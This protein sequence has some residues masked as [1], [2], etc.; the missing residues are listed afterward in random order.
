M[1]EVAV[2]GS[3]NTDLVVEVPRL[4]AVG[5][6]V[7]GSDLQVQPGGKGANQAIAAARL[8]AEVTLFAATGDD[9]FGS[10][11]RTVLAGENLNVSQVATIPDT[12]TGTAM[13]VVDSAGRNMITVAPGANSRLTE[14]Q[15]GNLRHAGD[16]AVVLL[17]LEIPLTTCRAAARIAHQA[18]ARV[19]LNAAPLND[20]QEAPLVELLADVDVLVVNEGEALQLAAGSAPDDPDGWADV[21]ANLRELGPDAV[22]VTLGGQG[23]VAATSEATHIQPAFVVDAVDT[24]GAGDAFCG[25]L[26]VE[27]ASGESLTSAVRAASAAGALA[28]THM[29]AQSALPTQKDVGRLLRT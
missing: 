24:T 15:L 28:T 23:A 8:G 13:I 11:V 12:P 19:V 10:H 3:I 5:E 29:G 20:P 6:T 25:A 27:L 21:A 18:G 22:V 7:L 4:P 9:E 16:D 17:Q 2:V 1:I 26:A 14:E